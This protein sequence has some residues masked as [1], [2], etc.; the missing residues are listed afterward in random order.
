MRLS[1]EG[2]SDRERDRDTDRDRA[3][4]TET[5]VLGALVAAC[6]PLCVAP[7]CLVRW[8]LCLRTPFVHGWVNDDP[9]MIVW[10]PLVCGK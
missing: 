5:E 9:K 8:S 4:E 2:S 3:Q 7:V 1:C 10:P 6:H